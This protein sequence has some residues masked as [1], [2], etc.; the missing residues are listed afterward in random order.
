[1]ISKWRERYEAKEAD[2]S[3][4]RLILTIKNQGTTA[5]P[6]P[7]TSTAPVVVTS[8]PVIQ[9]TMTTVGTISTPSVQLQPTTSCPAPQPPPETQSIPAPAVDASKEEFIHPTSGNTRKSRRLL[10]KDGRTTV[11]D[12]IDDVIRNGPSSC[13]MPS[14][15]APVPSQPPSVAPTPMILQ[16]FQSQQHVQVN[17][18][19]QMMS[20]TVQQPQLVH[21][22]PQHQ[23]VPMDLPGQTG[24]RN[25]R[26]NAT[27]RLIATV[28]GTLLSAET[29]L[30]PFPG[31]RKGYGP[32]TETERKGTLTVK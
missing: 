32:K 1:M 22:P 13:V 31:R 11:D 3:R 16:Q 9:P 18:V 5:T 12:I 26:H 7:S 28:P 25:T 24:R 10:E 20:P 19:N 17:Q 21:L 27:P 23:P 2:G 6:T 29:K 15:P 30:P 8:A 14:S 4:P